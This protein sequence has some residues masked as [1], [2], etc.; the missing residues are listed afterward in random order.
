MQLVK[1]NETHLPAYEQALMRGWSPDTER[2]DA[3]FEEL[4]RLRTNPTEFLQSLDDITAHAPVTLPDGSTAPRL[5]GFRRWMWDGDFCGSIGLR[6]E[7]GSA[8]L[9]PH[10]LGHIGYSVVP[11]KRG[12][13]YAT[14]A[15]RRILPEAVLQGLPYVELVTEET[16]EASQRV[17]RANGGTLVEHLMKPATHGGGRLCRFR[18]DLPQAMR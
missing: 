14:E 11:W 6:W 16:N 4:A 15:L 18:I 5:P 17:I 7:P 9:P 8:E 12:R 3:R 2:D 13:G 1:P 10:C